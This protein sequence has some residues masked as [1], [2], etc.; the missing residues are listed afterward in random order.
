VGFWGE[1]DEGGVG[2]STVVCDPEIEGD[3]KA[4]S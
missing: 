1:G 3:A 4:R 2:S